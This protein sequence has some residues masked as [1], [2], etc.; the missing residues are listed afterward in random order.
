MN[1]KV[2]FHLPGL[3]AFSSL[4]KNFLK[5][6]TE[7]KDK[8]NDWME[9]GSVFGAPR[10]ASWG[11]G[12]MPNPSEL[13]DKDI[14]EFMKNYNISC[15]LTFSNNQIEEK[16]LGDI[17]CNYLLDAFYW[18]GNSIIIN[19]P[20][21]EKYI[22]NKYPNYKF[23]S[24]TTKC[25]KDEKLTLDELSNDY[26]L[27]VLDYNFN[28]NFDFLINIENKEKCELLINPVCMPNCPRRKEHYDLMSKE[29][30]HIPNDIKYFECPYQTAKFFQAQNNPLFISKDD[31]QN[32]YI[33]M[34]F[35]HFKI[36]GRTT[37]WDD[38]IEILLYYLV[39]PE[40]QLEIRERL[41]YTTGINNV[42]Y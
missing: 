31:I 11:G 40:Y 27:V 20:I 35:K 16:H 15:R 12:R 23:I 34:G 7:E 5:I 2:Y 26:E 41:Y 32:I 14:I 25:L 19:S 29:F 9:I 36:E 1:N 39:K 42:I 33:P 28:K 8:F 38:L 10:T 24:S 4:Y 6:Y 18:P 21:L 22:R 37:G 30:L 3:F 17:Y 13:G